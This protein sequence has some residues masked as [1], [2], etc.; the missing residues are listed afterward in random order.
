ME[1][2]WLEHLNANF[3]PSAARGDKFSMFSIALEAW[4]RGLEVEFFTVK[5]KQKKEVN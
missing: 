4:R 3:I 1:K 5:R 2:E